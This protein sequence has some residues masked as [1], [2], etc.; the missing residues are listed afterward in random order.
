M[1]DE[2]RAE[3]SSYLEPPHR[4]MIRVRWPDRSGLRIAIDEL[5][6]D[7][8]LD[9]RALVSKRLE[10]AVRDGTQRGE[11]RWRQLD[12]HRVMQALGEITA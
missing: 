3:V 2:P 9:P 5:E 7:L 4:R 12:I 6:A 1:Q 10:L 8:A 11:A